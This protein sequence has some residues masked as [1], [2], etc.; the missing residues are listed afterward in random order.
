MLDIFYTKNRFLNGKLKITALFCL[1]ENQKSIS[2]FWAFFGGSGTVMT[3]W[4]FVEFLREAPITS[5]RTPILWCPR[6]RTSAS[7]IWCLPTRTIFRHFG[8]SGPVA[9]WKNLRWSKKVTLTNRVFRMRLELSGTPFFHH[10][11][12][13]LKKVF[14]VSKWTKMKKIV[15]LGSILR[16]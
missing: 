16:W 9:V 14:T 3:N 1:Q 10:F 13:F 11:L 5:V 15:I 12:C 2:I 8:R 7:E 4:R 6:P